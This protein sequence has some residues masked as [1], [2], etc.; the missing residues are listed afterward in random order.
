[1]PRGLLKN[2]PGHW[3]SEIVQSQS[4]YSCSGSVR[5]PRHGCAA[6]ERE[7]I[8]I[9][10]SIH[11]VLVVCKDN[12][13]KSPKTTEHSEKV[14]CAPLK[15]RS[16]EERDLTESVRFSRCRS[17]DIGNNNRLAVVFRENP[18]QPVRRTAYIVGAVELDLRTLSRQLFEQ[19]FACDVREVA[20][21]NIKHTQT[22]VIAQ[23]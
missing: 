2:Q 13:P 6:I 10:P 15:G 23:E 16:P 1:M 12:C 21:P 8:R 4:C 14:A 17:P 18:Q 22:L 9:E 7:T 11:R 5:L 20:T 19:R 3:L